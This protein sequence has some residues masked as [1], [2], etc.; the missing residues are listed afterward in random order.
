DRHE[1]RR[2]RRSRT[3][4]ARGP[5]RPHRRP[6][7]RRGRGEPPRQRLGRQSMKNQLGRV[8]FT[9]YLL[10]VL[11]WLV[12][13]ARA[14]N[15]NGA[16]AVGDRPPAAPAAPRAGWLSDRLPLRAGDLVTV[17]VDEQTAARERV[18]RVADGNRSMTA[19]LRA[20]TPSSTQGANIQSAMLDNSRDVG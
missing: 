7:D 17:V 2:A 18:S 4:A 3:R 13:V 5:R 9:L 16:P 19:R 12:T 15:T 10:V 20:D 6:R 1:W 8:L 14:Q 11:G